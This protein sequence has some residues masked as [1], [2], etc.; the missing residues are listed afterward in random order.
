MRGGDKNPD[1][2]GWEELRKF[3]VRT[4]V[5]QT[6]NICQQADMNMR[7]LKP[8]RVREAITARF[9]WTEE[10]TDMVLWEM[11]CDGCFSTTMEF[12]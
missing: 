10:F 7:N 6:L 5:G 1:F 8:S 3:A 9:E 4:A 2:P 11:E 12:G